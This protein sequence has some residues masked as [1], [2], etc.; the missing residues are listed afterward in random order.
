[1]TVAAYRA[2]VNAKKCRV[3]GVNSSSPA[4]GSTFCN[5]AQPDHDNH[6]VNC[7]TWEDA[8]TYCGWA[9]KRL[10]TEAEW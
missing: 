4:W 7:V 1:V 3:P 6:P 5:W 8:K 2:C 10:P 9:G